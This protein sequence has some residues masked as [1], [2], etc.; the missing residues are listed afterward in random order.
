MAVLS[1]SFGLI[2][3]INLRDRKDRLRDVTAELNAVGMQFTPDK[4]ELFAADRYTDAAG[5]ASV[6]ARGNF[7]SHFEVLRDAR[8]RGVQSVLVVEDDCEILTKNRTQIG[9]VAEALKDRVWGFAY[10][11]HIEPPVEGAADGWIPFIGP[12][13]TAHLYGVHRDALGP[14]VEYLEGCLRRPPGDPIGGPMLI[15]GA[16]TMFREAHPEIVTLIAQPVM[17]T[18]RSSKSDIT[19]RSYEA[20]PGIKQLFGWARVVRRKLKS[21]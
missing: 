13:Q 9:R 6:G 4:V 1:D 2:R 18:Q 14:L 7:M 11:G 19:F 10:L 21:R 15:D 8:D 20:L 16:I 5:F 3:V 17:A 12:L